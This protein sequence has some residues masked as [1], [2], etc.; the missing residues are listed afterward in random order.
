LSLD[1][2]AASSEKENKATMQSQRNKGRP[3]SLA[4]K[5]FFKAGWKNKRIARRGALPK[6]VG[7]HVE[8]KFL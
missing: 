6:S 1:E 3:P 5:K 7:G 4:K 8:V 2:E